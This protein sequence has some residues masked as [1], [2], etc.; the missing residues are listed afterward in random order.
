MLATEPIRDDC[1]AWDS[2]TSVRDPGECAVLVSLSP[3][4]HSVSHGTVVEEFPVCFLFFAAL[5]CNHLSKDVLLR[6]GGMLANLRD[7]KKQSTNAGC[8]STFI[9]V[10]RDGTTDLADSQKIGMMID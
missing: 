6:G 10:P 1:G 2:S 5:S 9:F 8:F 7:F 3:T 4:L